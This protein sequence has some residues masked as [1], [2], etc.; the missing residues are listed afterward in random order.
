MTDF[1]HLVA[2]DLHQSPR[3][4]GKN[5]FF[6]CPFH[7]GG[8]ERTA[9][10]KVSNGNSQH[11]PGFYCF[12]CGKHGGPVKYFLERG[13]SLDEAQRMAGIEAQP[14]RYY[15][16]EERFDP[17]QTPPGQPW[18]K[19]AR[20]FLAY[21]RKHFATT[22]QAHGN[23]TDFLI[24]DRETGQQYLRRMAPIEWWIERGLSVPTGEDWGIGYNPKDVYDNGVNWGLADK[25][26]VWLPQGFVIPCT[27]DGVVWYIK[28][29]RPKGKP[30]FIHVP[31][32]VPALYMAE[33][34]EYYST[35]VFTE[36]ELDALLLWQEVNFAGAATFGAATT[37]LNVATWGLRLL[38]PKHRLVAYDLDEAG[39]NGAAEL[40]RF[41]FI[42]LNV[43]K[44][45]PFDKDLTDYHLSA[46][47]LADWL[48]GELAHLYI[49]V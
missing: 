47:R 34:L 25:T 37:R 21:A 12:S 13:Y 24:L 2:T 3:K 40:T 39:K 10:L 41:G 38:Y 1:I 8:N 6:K 43:P 23:E 45:R 35:V 31:G 18:Q 17:P 5:H 16:P 32:S 36:G 19:R 14:G 42:R 20:E 28:I 26:S 11:G 33:N 15:Q 44:V 48:Q 7:G 27:L 22:A 49:E 4:V 30:K 46:G 29:R 9:S